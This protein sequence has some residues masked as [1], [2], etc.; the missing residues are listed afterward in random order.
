MTMKAGEYV[1]REQDDTPPKNSGEI[2]H[3]G[4]ETRK[5]SNM[6]HRIVTKSHASDEDQ[7]TATKGWILGYLA[8]NEERD[9]YQRELEE[10]FCL[11][12]A[13]VS[14]VMQLM[15]QKGFITRQ[16]DE[17]DARL[18]KI[19]LTDKGRR[20]HLEALAE[21]D[22]IERRVTEGI[23]Q[24]KL[25][26]FFEVCELMKKNLYEMEENGEW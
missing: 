10:R 17:H 8:L 14:K 24:D 1:Y 5:I 13:S 7:V 2:R 11:R 16:S 12:R 23:S 6:I 22:R 26:I 4:A 18:K 25:D 19:K 3:V 15:E 20:Q 21:F 9:V